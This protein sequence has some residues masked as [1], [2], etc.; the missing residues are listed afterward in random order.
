MLMGVSFHSKSILRSLRRKENAK[1]EKEER[2]S[3]IDKVEKYC[4]AWNQISGGMKGNQ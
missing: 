3:E 4:S 2:E 1:R